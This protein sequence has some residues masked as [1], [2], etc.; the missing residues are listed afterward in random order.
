MRTSLLKRISQWS[1]VLLIVSVLSPVAAL[2]DAFFKDVRYS[3]AGTVTG[4]VYFNGSVG[5]DVYGA[6]N[7]T[8]SVYDAAGVYITSINAKYSS[9]SGGNYYYTFDP[10]AITAT[11]SAYNPIT[12]RYHNETLNYTAVSDAVY[13]QSPPPFIADPGTTYPPTTPTTPTTPTAPGTAPSLDAT[14]SGSVDADALK[15]AFSNSDTV[16][17]KFAQSIALPA[18]GLTD[19]VLK[20]GT[21]LILVGE[22][23]TYELLLSVLDLEEL[24]RMLGIDV[25]DLKI[26]LSITVVTGDAADD[27]IAAAEAF[28]ASTLSAPISFTLVAEGTD[29]T[30]IS[31]DSF[32][33][34]YVKRTI[35][36]DKSPNGIAT[37]ALYNP[38]TDVLSFVPSTISE[39][40][41]TFQRPGNSIYVVIDNRATF[42]DLPGHWARTEIELLASKLLYSKEV[43]VGTGDGKFEPDAAITRAEYAALVVKALGLNLPVAVTNGHFRDVDPKMWYSTYIVSAAE[44]HLIEGYEDGS[45]KASQNISREELIALTVRALKFAGGDAVITASE[46]EAALDQFSD[47]SDL[48]WARVEA[49]IAIDQEIVT[50][51]AGGKLSPLDDATRAEAAVLLK[52]MLDKVGFINN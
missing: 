31:L 19:A 45:F 29:G 41:A 30:K 9:Q 20:E 7:V 11:Y 46:Y 24:A 49:A 4:E 28:G 42:D 6:E 21:K 48:I 36:L 23:G 27:V 39:L 47:I 32:G 43:V 2:A 50:G 25:A 10:T 18:A 17:V 16:Q 40:T 13:K 52:R 51:T 5:S 35:K 34:T 3:S 8:L 22:H 37:V 38:L 15:A 12:I 1:V 33:S 44:A 14:A 26:S